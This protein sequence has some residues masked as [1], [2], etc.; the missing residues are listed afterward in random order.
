MITSLSLVKFKSFEEETLELC[1]LT[2]L[3]GLN[4][5][6][7]S[8][9][10]QALR[11]LHEQKALDGFGPLAGYIKDDF[12]E[13]RLECQQIIKNEN[14]N[15]YFSFDRKNTK[16]EYGERIDN[17]VSYISADRYG[18]RN[19]LPLGIDS[20]AA[21]VG[22]YGENIVAF[23]ARLDS[24]WADLQVPRVFGNEGSGVKE[25]IREWL[26]VISPGVQFDYYPDTNTDTGRTSFNDHRPVHVGFGLSYALPVIASVLIHAAQ[27]ASG[28][29]SQAIL[30]IENPEAH[31]HPS[32]QA[33]L[34]ELFRGTANQK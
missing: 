18:P 9:V 22:R 21:A 24:D 27:I 17:I 13:F 29:H 31:I 4:S 20:E 26:R 32:A 19:A 16:A 25:E 23:L 15:I 30:L 6:G 3:S 5:S 33:K 2:I 10:I 28:V 1:P 8:S 11:L 14:K 12:G 34:M 7:K